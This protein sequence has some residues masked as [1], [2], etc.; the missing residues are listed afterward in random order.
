MYI[1]PVKTCQP[2]IGFFYFIDLMQVT[3]TDQIKN[4][5]RTGSKSVWTHFGLFYTAAVWGSTFFVVKKVCWG[6]TR[7]CWW[8]IGF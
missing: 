2:M 5:R 7:L 4:L 6:S 8:R 1:M 3:M